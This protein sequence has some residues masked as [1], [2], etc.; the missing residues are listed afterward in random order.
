MEVINKTT[1]EKWLDLHVRPNSIFSMVVEHNFF[2]R[3]GT[4]RKVARRLGGERKEHG[5]EFGKDHSEKPSFQKRQVRNVPY[6]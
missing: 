3:L 2:G 5:W 1:P 6:C 4:C